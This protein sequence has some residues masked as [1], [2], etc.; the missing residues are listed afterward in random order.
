MIAWLAPVLC[1]FAATER[2]PSASTW[3]RTSTRAMPAGIGGMPVSRKRASERQSS[4]SS[5]SPCSTWMSSAFCPSWKVVKTCAA[6]VGMVAVARDELLDDAAHRL[7]PERERDDVEQQHL[8]LA[9]AVGEQVRL[10]RRAQR[11]HLVRVD[12]PERLAAEELRRRSGAPPARASPAHQ[13][14]AVQLAAA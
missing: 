3:K 10:H 7:Q 4:T 9:L 1:S 14:D 12:V 13:D 2:M 11:H 6:A 5:R 8:V